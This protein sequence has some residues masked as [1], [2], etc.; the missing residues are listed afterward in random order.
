MARLG[1]LGTQYEDDAGN[2]LISGKIFIFESGTTTPK[3]TFADINLTLLNTNPIILTAAGRQPNV[4][5]SGSIKAVLTDSDENQIQVIDPI[6]GEGLEGSFSDWNSLTI[7][8]IP[9]IVVAD[10]KFYISITDGN[11]NND[12][13][14]DLTNWTEIKFTRVWNTNETYPLNALVQAI[15]GSLYKSTID[16]NTA[17]DPLTDVVNWTSA[18]AVSI[19]AVIRS[20]AK[21]FAYRN[22]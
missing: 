17:N 14:T 10:D 4:F 11:Q 1:T 12:P 13:T 15:D 19:P 20:S 6:G 18:V 2:P 5:F 3:D 22:F 21:T 16:N 7:Y 9:D 8:N